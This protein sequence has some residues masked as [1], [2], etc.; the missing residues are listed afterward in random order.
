MDYRWIIERHYWVAHEE[1]PPLITGIFH[2]TANIT[3]WF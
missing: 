3:D 2:D 1:K